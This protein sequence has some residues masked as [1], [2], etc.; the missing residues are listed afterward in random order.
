M[1]CQH[2][3][4]HPYCRILLWSS[5]LRVHEL[6]ELARCLINSDR[7]LYL[8]GRT[9][10]LF[11]GWIS[12]VQLGGR[13]T[14]RTLSFTRRLVFGYTEQLC[15]IRSI[16]HLGSNLIVTMSPSPRNKIFFNQSDVKSWV[17]HPFLL[18]GLYLAYKTRQSR[19]HCIPIQE[20]NV[21]HY[22]ILQIHPYM[23]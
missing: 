1:P 5:V 6:T 3:I 14:T 16:L 8:I 12:D 18:S 2:V 9:S 17:T 22:L 15:K 19:R 7:Y 20:L 11:R 23:H 10:Q 21:H 13:Y 4:L